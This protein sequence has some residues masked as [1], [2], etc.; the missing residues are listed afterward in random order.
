ELFDNNPYEVTYYRLNAVDKD[1]KAELS[2]TINVKRE[3]RLGRMS[4]SPNP[5]SSSISLQTVST[6]DETGTVTV[7]EMTGKI[8]MSE[9]INL[10][11]GLNTYSIDL[12]E[13]NTGIYLFS[14]QTLE[15]V[16][17]EKIVKQ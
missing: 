3:D 1:G 17:V 8:V 14:L 7:Y 5:T 13:L 10:R 2:H 11:N 12:N 6:T 15:G 16:Q 9:S 4:L